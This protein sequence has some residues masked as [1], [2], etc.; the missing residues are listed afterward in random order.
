[1]PSSNRDRLVDVCEELVKM[2]VLLLPHAELLADRYSEREETRIKGRLL[3]QTEKETEK[4]D[5]LA[6]KAAHQAHAT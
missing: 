1:M 3:T 5:V 2:S 6:V 4:D